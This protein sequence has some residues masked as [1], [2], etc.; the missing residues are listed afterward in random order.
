[1]LYIIMLGFMEVLKGGNVIMKLIFCIRVDII[2]RQPVTREKQGHKL[3]F[4]L[5]D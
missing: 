1:M 5:C 4:L 2:E 3:T